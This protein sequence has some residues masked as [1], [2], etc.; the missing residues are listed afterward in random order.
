[1]QIVRMCLEIHCQRD[2]LESSIYW[3]DFSRNSFILDICRVQDTV[4][5]YFIHFLSI[6]FLCFK[7]NLF[8]ALDCITFEA[9]TRIE[10]N[11]TVLSNQSYKYGTAVQSISASVTRIHMISDNCLASRASPGYKH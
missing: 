10:F 4:A 3:N 5:V 9:I 1:M 7:F 6:L 8:F 11:E 2:I